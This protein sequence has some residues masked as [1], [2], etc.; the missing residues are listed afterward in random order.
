IIL[1]SSIVIAYLLTE[2]LEKPLRDKNRYKR[3]QFFYF[4]AMITLIL[5]FPL[6]YLLLNQE[7]S[8]ADDLPSGYNGAKQVELSEQLNTGQTLYPAPMKAKED[9]A[10]SYDDGCNVMG[11][12]PEVKV[13]YYGAKDDYTKTIA[14]V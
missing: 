8:L 3:L 6:T 9:L 5:S 11:N 12:S 10:V 4:P 1:I 2:Y 13:C 7:D 14:L